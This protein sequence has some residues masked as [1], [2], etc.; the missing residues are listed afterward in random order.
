MAVNYIYPE[1]EIVRDADKCIGCRVC[2]RQ[3]S[4]NVHRYDAGIDKMFSD[5]KSCFACHRCV[6]LC[7]TRALKVVK[8]DNT[9][10]ENANWSKQLIE[11]VYR[12]AS[13]GGV[14]LSSMGNPNPL[15]VYWDRILINA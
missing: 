12:Q 13:T 14:L 3:C 4:N 1:F 5:S 15:P 9:F 7:P 2:E 6:S 11:E 10:R 8:S